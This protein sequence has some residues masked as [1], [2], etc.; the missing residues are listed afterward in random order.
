MMRNKKEKERT[1]GMNKFQKNYQNAIAN[2]ERTSGELARIEKPF[3]DR[4][5]AGE[6]FDKVTA[7]YEALES[8]KKASHEYWKAFDARRDAQE[9]LLNWS[10]KVSFQAATDSEKEKLEDL[11]KNYRKN[12]NVTCKLITL[13]MQINPDA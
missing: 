6:D 12:Y 4:I 5:D 11:Q 13:A 10:F 7:E 1:D 8:W 2:M 9:D 3:E